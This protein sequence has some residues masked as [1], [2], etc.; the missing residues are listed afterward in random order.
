MSHKRRLRRIEDQLRAGERCI[1]IDWGRDGQPN[2]C[3]QGHTDVPGPV[4]VGCPLE[5]DGLHVKVQWVKG[6]RG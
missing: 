4:C 2:R 5:A 1:L 6:R 3:A